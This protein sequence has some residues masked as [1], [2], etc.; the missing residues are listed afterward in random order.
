MFIGADLPGAPWYLPTGGIYPP[1]TFQ[2]NL[3]G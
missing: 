2:V 1:G 3:K